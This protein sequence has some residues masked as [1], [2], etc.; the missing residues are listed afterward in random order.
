MLPHGFKLD[1][2]GT[3]CHVFPFEIPKIFSV[4]PLTRVLGG[5]IF[6]EHLGAYMV[7]TWKMRLRLHAEDDPLASLII[8]SNQ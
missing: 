1:R 7:S 4:R 5:A 8:G 3:Q 6:M 2:L